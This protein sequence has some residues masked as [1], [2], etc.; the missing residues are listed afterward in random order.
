MKFS[1]LNPLLEDSSVLD[2][3]EDGEVRLFK[4]PTAELLEKLVKQHNLIRGLLIGKDLYVWDAWQGIHS[5]I[6]RALGG[7]YVDGL[8]FGVG[9]EDIRTWAGEFIEGHTFQVGNVYFASEHG[10]EILFQNWPF[11]AQWAKRRGGIKEFPINEGIDSPQEARTG[12]LG[13]RKGSLPVNGQIASTGA[14]IEAKRVIK[15]ELIAEMRVD[16]DLGTINVYKNLNFDALRPLMRRSKDLTVRGLALD[17][18]IY[19]WDA[20]HEDHFH[21]MNI[22]GITKAI[23]LELTYTK[24]EGGY[25]LE[26]ESLKKCARNAPVIR[27][28]K[29]IGN[30]YAVIYEDLAEAELTVQEFLKQINLREDAIPKP[31]I[32]AE[33]KAEQQAFIK[34]ADHLKLPLKALLNAYRHGVLVKLSDDMW[35]QLENTES[36]M[37]QPWMD[38]L[39]SAQAQGNNKFRHDQHYDHYP[40]VVKYGKH[41][42]LYLLAGESHLV[43]E[44][45]LDQ[46]P[47]VI[48]V[49]ATMITEAPISNFDVDPD[50]SANEKKMKAQFHGY[51][52]EQ[53]MYSEKDKMAITSP[54][55]IQKL[56]R[57]FLRVPYSF[58]LYFWHQAQPDYDP[59]VQKG[60]V[61]D[62]WIAK[63]MGKQV[64]QNISKYDRAASITIIMTGN[65]SDNYPI[66][67]G[68]S[69]IMGHR[70]AHVLIAGNE[71][72]AFGHQVID[73]FFKFIEHITGTGYGVEWPKD[74]FS[75][76]GAIM[77]KEYHEI[78]GKVLGHALGTMASARN[79]K[80][81]NG[82]EWIYETFAQ[83]LLTGK[84]E[85]NPLPKDMGEGEI[86][87]N[88]P[89]KMKKVLKL[90][91]RF[92]RALESAFAKMLA[93]SVGKTWVM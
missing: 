22:L 56:K 71:T 87:T 40:I 12:D 20:Y 18:E 26:V 25:F 6:S 57:A 5:Q 39:K 1:D 11:F 38:A 59:Y 76:Y 21:M 4:N 74:K 84:V 81:V 9:Y 42:R 82:Y 36:Y 93:D 16:T 2:L 78:Y 24:D 47:E 34:T 19:W 64:L 77:T 30:R 50:F 53:P 7:G 37:F 32:K 17:K 79:G 55:H 44:R 10:E 75:Q 88:D 86:L 51:N 41:G 68:S 31:V 73:M 66:N 62:R 3:G 67:F 54:A 45:L 29:S 89:V 15:D 65:L 27:F 49:D 8:L 63:H 91:N 92:P 46:T 13:L 52:K 83:Y 58:N 60:I 35:S 85:F 72:T 14:V 80:L 69:W 28:L 48:L 61:D 70:I 33:F 23:T 43:S 90:Y